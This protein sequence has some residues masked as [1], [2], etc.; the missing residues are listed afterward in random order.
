M[1]RKAIVDAL[2]LCPDQPFDFVYT[3]RRKEVVSAVDDIQSRAVYATECFV[4]G[5]D[6]RDHVVPG[7]NH[8]HRAARMQNGSI[9]E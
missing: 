7:G 4:Q 9:F 3:A 8:M 2:E 6:G 5:V 1:W